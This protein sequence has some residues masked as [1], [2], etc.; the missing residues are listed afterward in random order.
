VHVVNGDELTEDL[1]SAY[2]DDELDASTRR[3]VDARLAESAAWRSILAEVEE[4]RALLRAAPLPEAPPGFW[5]ET[6]RAVAAEPDPDPAPA[7]APAAI[8]P[9]RAGRRTRWLLAATAAAA[10]VVAAVVL[11]PTRTQTRPP[12]AA[13]MSTHAARSSLTDEPISQL[14]P[15]ATPVRLDR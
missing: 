2:A 14:A 5:E 10:V 1:L 4:T 8:G 15:M 13:M 11:V 3:E 6:H 12:V 7:P 9:A